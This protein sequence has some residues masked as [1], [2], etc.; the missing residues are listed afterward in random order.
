VLDLL[1]ILL[2]VLVG[3]I[4][5]VKEAGKPE[6]GRALKRIEVQTG[7]THHA[8]PLPFPS[9]QIRPPTRVTTRSQDDSV[10]AILREAADEARALRSAPRPLA[11]WRGEAWNDVVD[12]N[13]LLEN[14]RTSIIGLVQLSERNLQAARSQAAMNNRK[15]AAELAVTSVE[16]I[17][18]ALLHCYGEKPEQ[19]PGQEEPLRLLSRRLQGEEK[20]QFEKAVG[21]T[22][23]LCRERTVQAEIPEKGVEAPSLCEERTQHV[24]GIATRIV[25]Q[26]KHIIIENFAT[27]IPELGEWCPECGAFTVYLW[28]FGPE[29]STCQC[30][31]CR[32]SWTQPT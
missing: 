27:E 25:A 18:R 19:N 23:Q 24:L 2:G 16:N 5:T 14:W 13:H 4:F 10:P 1:I 12:G 29:G 9:M 32:H 15:A 11:S 6:A 22:A 26:F 8:M 7:S 30:S 28:A 3:L 17:S 21:E 20:A 31:T